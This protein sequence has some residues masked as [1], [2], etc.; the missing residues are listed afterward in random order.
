[1]NGIRSQELPR[2]P[3]NE[4]HFV[5]CG[6]PLTAF[7]PTRPELARLFSHPFRSLGPAPINLSFCW[8][9]SANGSAFAYLNCV[10]L[11]IS[12]HNESGSGLNTVAVS[13]GKM[14]H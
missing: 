6:S 9:L 14:N 11:I 1:M 10:F 2:S 4:T 8:E 13:A 3:K 12:S 7:S 5:F